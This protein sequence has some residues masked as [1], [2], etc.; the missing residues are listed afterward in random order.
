LVDGDTGSIVAEGEALRGD[1][2]FGTIEKALARR[3]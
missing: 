3:Q 1:K 2:L